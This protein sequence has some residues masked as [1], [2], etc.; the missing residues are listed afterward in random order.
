MIPIY[1]F[2]ANSE[3]CWRELSMFLVFVFFFFEI[4]KIKFNI[5]GLEKCTIQP[6]KGD[7]ND[8]KKSS[9]VIKY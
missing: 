5:V 8:K 3:N 6:Y 9:M 7:V 2:C 1:H 4:S